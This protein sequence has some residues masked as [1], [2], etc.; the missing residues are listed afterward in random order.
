MACHAPLAHHWGFPAA[1]R[2]VEP[3]WLA[4]WWRV[5]YGTPLALATVAQ[6]M[7]KEIFTCTI[8]AEKLHQS[9]EC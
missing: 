8:G 7:D 2:H 9:V 5:A 4:V 6:P 1:F 3:S